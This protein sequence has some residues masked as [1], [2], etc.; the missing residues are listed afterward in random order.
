MSKRMMITMATMKMMLTT[1]LA[2]FAMMRTTMTMMA[3]VT[4]S[5]R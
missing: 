2:R 5:Q 1:I 4:S 3:A